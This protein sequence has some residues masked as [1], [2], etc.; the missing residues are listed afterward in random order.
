MSKRTIFGETLNTIM[1]RRKEITERAKEDIWKRN[2][3]VLQSS[4]KD[5]ILD[6][7]KIM[8]PNGEE[9]FEYK[10]Y[11]KIDSSIVRIKAEVKYKIEGGNE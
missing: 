4:R 6:E 9:V 5:Y 7:Q 10:L 11:K 3:L 2:D 8:L 1:K